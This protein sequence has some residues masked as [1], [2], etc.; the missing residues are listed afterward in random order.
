MGRLWRSADEEGS[1]K[2]RS[3]VRRQW[4]RAGGWAVRSLRKDG[5]RDREGKCRRSLKSS[6]GPLLTMQ[7]SSDRG[8]IQDF[9]DLIAPSAGFLNW[10]THKTSNL[11]N[12]LRCLEN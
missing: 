9:R 11:R 1:E 12:T 7:K 2:G 5:D 8:E 3:L 10:N 6:L 4:C